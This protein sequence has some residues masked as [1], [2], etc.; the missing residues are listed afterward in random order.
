[1]PL[2]DI[3]SALFAVF[4]AWLVCCF[5]EGIR[6]LYFHPLSKFPGP[7]LAALT[8]WYEFYYDIIEPGTYFR[9]IE[10]MHREYGQYNLSNTPGSSLRTGS[11]TLNRTHSPY[12]SSR[13]PHPRSCL[14]RSSL[15]RREAG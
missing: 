15:R 8:L 5:L 7:K 11:S 3:Q 13:A 12:Q 4:A 6:R 9:K 1:M 2:L 14:L 10:E